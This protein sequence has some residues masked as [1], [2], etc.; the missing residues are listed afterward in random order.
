MNITSAAAASTHAV[1]PL[2]TPIAFLLV[3]ADWRQ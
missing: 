1:S 3:F 2:L